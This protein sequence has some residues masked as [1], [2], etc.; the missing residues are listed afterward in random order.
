MDNFFQKKT[1]HG[2]ELFGQAYAGQYWKL[3]VGMLME[4]LGVSFP[5]AREEIA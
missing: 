1:F 4:I 2:G 3:F 5:I